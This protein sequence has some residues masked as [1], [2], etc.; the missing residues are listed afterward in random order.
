MSNIFYEGQAVG[1]LING[2]GIVR[3]ILKKNQE[4]VIVEFEP[5]GRLIEYS[6]FGY[7]NPLSFKPTLYPI[8]Q[9]REIIANLPAPQ[10]E[11]WKPKPG[12]W[13]WFWDDSTR[14]GVLD[15]FQYADSGRYYTSKVDWQNC[16]PF[17]GDLPP[18]LKEVQPCTCT[19]DETTGATQF[20]GEE[21]RCNICGKKVKQ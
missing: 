15:Q 19:P 4:R 6:L 1:C 11:A 10:P 9:F 3:S 17:T 21:F 20:P 7:E 12:D 18:H 5:D 8:D 2:E 13:C 14:I 16:A